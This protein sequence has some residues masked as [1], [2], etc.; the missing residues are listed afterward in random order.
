MVKVSMGR[1]NL[2][3]WKG[4]IPMTVSEAK[5]ILRAAVDRVNLRSGTKVDASDDAK[6]QAKKK[7]SLSS[8]IEDAK[9]RQRTGSTL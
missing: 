2:S 6:P 4:L 9:R 8:V 5:V 1:A 7:R 3:M